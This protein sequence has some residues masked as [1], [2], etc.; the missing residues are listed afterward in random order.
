M[1]TTVLPVFAFQVNN[2]GIPLYSERNFR[3]L[4]FR[5]NSIVAFAS[6]HCKR[7]PNGS[8][9]SDTIVKGVSVSSVNWAPE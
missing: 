4:Q 7:E 2:L 1:L 6:Y 5:Q 9:C 3:R 8:G